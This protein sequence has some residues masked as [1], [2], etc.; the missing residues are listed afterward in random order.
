MNRPRS[1]LIFAVFGSLGLALCASGCGDEGS[2]VRQD[3]PVRVETPKSAAKNG[4]PA[5]STQINGGTA[6]APK[7]VKTGPFDKSFEGIHFSIPAGWDE[8]ENPTPDFIDA[9]FQIPTSHGPVKLT[10]SSNPGGI[11]VNIKRWIGQFQLPPDK[12]PTVGDLKVDG[13]TARWV[14][15]RGEFMGGGMGGVPVSSGPV[16][17]MLGVA[18]P[19]GARD[20]YLKLTG[21]D[22]AVSEIRDAFREFVRSARLS[23]GG[24]SGK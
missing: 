16:E 14:D 21:T 1:L 12:Q 8:V 20:F 2:T 15:L 6:A 24:S 23:S 4:S 7:V 18:I 9:R 22:A 19:L 10:F 11:D 3:P 13:V 17:R 5:H